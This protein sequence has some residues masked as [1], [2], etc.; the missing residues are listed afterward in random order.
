MSGVF[1]WL[2]DYVNKKWVKAPAAVLTIRKTGIGQVGTAEAHTLYWIS[3]NPSAANSM[4]ELTDATAGG[5]GVVFDMYHATRDHMHMVLN[6]PMFF[7]NG[8]YIETLTSFTSV[9][10][11]YI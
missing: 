11:G 4:L 7:T 1:L 5:S 8:I 2:W 10:F 3:M 6:P 9:M